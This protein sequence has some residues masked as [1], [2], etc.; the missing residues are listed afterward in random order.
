MSGPE[1]IPME[2][3]LPVSA[4][5]EDFLTSPSNRPAWDA[6]RLWQQWPDRR[7]IL[8][9][10]EGAG[11]SHLVQ[12]WAALTGAVTASAIE[13][14]ETRM[15]QLLEYEAVAIEDV[16]RIATLP[17]PAKRQI[18][19]ILFHL[20]NLAGAGPVPLL[21]TD[22]GAPAHWRIET[23]DLASRVQAVAH[24]RIPEP[25]DELLASILKKLF[26]DRQM[27]VSDDV[28]EYLVRRIE[29][30][31]ASAERIVA[32]LDRAALVGQRGI[33]RP[34]AAAVLTQDA[35]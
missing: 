26:T 10:P 6:I 4:S 35:D 24:V 2:L 3:P 23:P 34:L 30:S 22:R 20:F 17:G 19:A 29:R 1:Q 16:D 31:F 27:Q 21:M 11:K 7:L 14:T 33:T 15:V 25:D 9:G 32:R 5:G 12:I 8:T 18:E 28:I 13:L